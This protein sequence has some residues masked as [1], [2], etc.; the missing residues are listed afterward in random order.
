MLRVSTNGSPY[1]PVVIL[2][3]NDLCEWLRFDF[4]TEK[5]G[6]TR[7]NIPCFLC[8][9]V[10]FNTSQ[11]P[12]FEHLHWFVGTTLRTHQNTRDARH[13]VSTNPSKH[14]TNNPFTPQIRCTQYPFLYI[15]PPVIRHNF[16]KRLCKQSNNT[17]Y[18]RC[19]NG[20]SL[21]L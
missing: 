10:A 14:L 11:F 18:T 15:I 3:I 5:H 12:L 7:K 16:K 20:N 17:R 4:A 1:K 21:F 2:Q 19:Q 13:R 9:S 6:K 8:H